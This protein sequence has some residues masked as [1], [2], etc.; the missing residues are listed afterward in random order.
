MCMGPYL[1]VYVKGIY[2]M[3]ISYDLNR[4]GQA[5]VMPHDIVG[6]WENIL[7]TSEADI[8]S[9]ATLYG[10][11]HKEPFSVIKSMDFLYRHQGEYRDDPGFFI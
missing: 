2:I 11:S 3:M 1:F 6:R 4:F 7:F 5:I 8:E 9:L 10:M